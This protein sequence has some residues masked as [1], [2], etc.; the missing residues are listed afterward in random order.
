MKP[1]TPSHTRP[2]AGINKNPPEAR[3]ARGVRF[4][5]SEW[6]QVRIAA[7]KRGI[8][9]GSF[10][11][12]AAM[13]HAALDLPAENAPLPPQFLELMKHTFRYV[14]ALST[15]KRNE[16]IRAGHRDEVNKAADFARK[17]EAELLS[18]A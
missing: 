7:A 9:F 2:A 11:R 17:A 18:G 13:T 12:E 4:S 10:V 5:E 3:H 16:L 15:M 1:N 14:C 8:S 6:N